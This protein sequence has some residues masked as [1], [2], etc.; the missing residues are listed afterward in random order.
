MYQDHAACRVCG[1][2]TELRPH[3]ATE[4]PARATVRGDNDST[5]DERVCTNG[6]CAT[7]G[8]GPDAPAP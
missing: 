8:G 2:P 6:D 5:V 4:D 7:N 1:S 3:R